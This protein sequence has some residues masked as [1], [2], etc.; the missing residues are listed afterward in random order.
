MSSEPTPFWPAGLK[1]LDELQRAAE[2]LA[3]LRAAHRSGLLA[4]LAEPH[5][6]TDLAAR[7]S[8]PPSRVVALLSL[9]SAFGIV[10]SRDARWALLPEWS[11][12][13]LGETPAS[14]RPSIGMG[15]IRAAQFSTC[16]EDSRDYW[17]LDAAERLTM[18][19]GV[20]PNPRSPISVAIAQA[21]LAPL[22]E[23]VTALENGG[24]ILELGCGVASRLCA[25]LLAFPNASAVG[26]EL[27]EDLL[28][29]ARD[30]AD[31]LGLGDRLTLVATDAGN[32]H[33]DGEFD[34]VGWSQFFFPVESRA[35]ALTTALRALRPGGWITMPVVWDGSIPEPGSADDQELAADRLMLD[36]WDVPALNAG[37]VAAELEAAGFVN[38]RT[39]ASPVATFIRAQKA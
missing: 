9:L 8:L 27:A 5:S 25:L 32:Y 39:H 21:D 17:T 38:V 31:R 4:T 30:R 18:A 15:A 35:G 6:S 20:S 24:R 37:E 19:R 13:I 34:L 28:E 12:L 10:E 2:G 22:P 14:F 7:L 11:G 23:V 33:P 3:A 1:R 29:Y 36:L 16:L 26:I